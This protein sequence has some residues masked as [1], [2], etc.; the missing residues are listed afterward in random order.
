M[1]EKPLN[2]IVKTL[3]DKNRDPMADRGN[4]INQGKLDRKNKE[5]HGNFVYIGGF[6]DFVFY[7]LVIL[8][9]HLYYLNVLQYF[10]R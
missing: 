6:I 4:W 2:G 10:R 3:L 9:K 1:W 8:Y 7:H 5:R